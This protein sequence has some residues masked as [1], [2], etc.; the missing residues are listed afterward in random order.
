MLSRTCIT[1]KTS[2]LLV[3]I[4]AHLCRF[5]ILPLRRKQ[6]HRRGKRSGVLVRLKAALRRG[7]SA[8]F[9]MCGLEPRLSYPFRV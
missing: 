4:P 2:T 5:W 9:G 7:F 6:A 1:D 8:S 3:G